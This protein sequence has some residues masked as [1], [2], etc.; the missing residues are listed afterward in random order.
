[1]LSP[2]DTEDKEISI[3]KLLSGV[4]R[5]Y[6]RAEAYPKEEELARQ[7]WKSIPGKGNNRGREVYQRAVAVISTRYDKG[8]TYIVIMG[9]ERRKQI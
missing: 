9:L 1:M 3:F 4:R 8:L 5:F 7:N 6:R 2:G